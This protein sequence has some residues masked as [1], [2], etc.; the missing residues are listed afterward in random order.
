MPTLAPL[1]IHELGGGRRPI[2]VSLGTIGA[3]LGWWLE[4]A[5]RLEA[6]G[7]AGVWAWDHHA[8][9]GPRRPTLEA[10]TTLTAAAAATSHIAIGSHVL[11][12][13]S[14]HPAVL[15]RMA[16][17]LHELAGPR[18]VVG[19]G[20]GGRRS[21]HEPLGIPLPEAPERVARLEEAV[22][23]LRALWTGGPV[24]LPGPYYPLRDALSAPAPVPPPPI[25]LAGQTP[26]G[27]ASPLAWAT[28]GP[29]PASGSS[30][31]ARR[32]R[33]SWRRRAGTGPR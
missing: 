11:N 30:G 27:H 25:L 18:L 10:W 26:A 23:V 31:S 29:C 1:R 24:T 14:R 33:A 20:I 13:M 28:A 4:S 6:A 12:V 3:S 32:S 19:L 8:A 22:A 2:G 21:D 16:T 15:A 5:R 17:T 9:G 7:Y